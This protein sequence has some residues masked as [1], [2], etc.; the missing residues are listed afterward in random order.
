[1]AKLPLYVM[2]LKGKKRDYDTRRRSIPLKR[3]FTMRESESE[4]ARARAS[5]STFLGR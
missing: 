5:E 1:M 4:S 2:N 3:D